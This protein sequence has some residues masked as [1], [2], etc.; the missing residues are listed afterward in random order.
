MSGWRAEGDCGHAAGHPVVASAE[1]GEDWA[2]CYPDQVM[3]LPAS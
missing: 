1:R 3:L 2:W